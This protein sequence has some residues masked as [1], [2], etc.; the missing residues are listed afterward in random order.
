MVVAIIS[1]VPIGHCNQHAL[2]LVDVQET[3]VLHRLKPAGILIRL[4]GIDARPSRVPSPDIEE[5][6]RAESMYP[7]P[8]IVSATPGPVRET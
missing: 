5:K 2:V 6:S 3:S 1:R 7:T 8:A 4:T